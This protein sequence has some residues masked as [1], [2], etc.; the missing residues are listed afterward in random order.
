[1]PSDF[2]K[3]TGV[4]VVQNSYNLPIRRFEFAERGN[5]IAPQAGQSIV[6]WYIPTFTR[7][8]GDSDSFDFL[9]GYE[10]YVIV[11]AA[12][13]ML[14]KEE[15]DVQAMM[16]RKQAL[17]DRINAMSDNRDANEPYRITDID[18]YNYSQRYILN[19]TNLRYRLR[20]SNL[21]L[22]EWAAWP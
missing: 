8:S 4:D 13:K 17:L 7:L 3:L 20:S 16:I 9:N 6:L 22:M 1:L 21:V 18:N 11:D 5:Y 10:E 12:I 2:Y 14:G 19:P 15:S